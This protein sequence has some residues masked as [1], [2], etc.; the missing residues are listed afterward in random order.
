[1]S[2]HAI[3]Y[4]HLRFLSTGCVHTSPLALFPG[5]ELIENVDLLLQCR[6][7]LLQIGIDLGLVTA[8]LRIEV[9]PVWRSAHGG[10]KYGLHDEA[11]VW[12]ESVCVCTPEAVG[13]LLVGVLKILAEGERSEVQTAVEPQQTFSGRVLLRGEF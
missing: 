4:H 12:L 3:V 1:M 10:V 13:E 11:V 5:T 8:H 6:Q 9:L 2:D 7:P